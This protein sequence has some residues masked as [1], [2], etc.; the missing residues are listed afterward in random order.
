MV[1]RRRK[2]DKALPLVSDGPL[3]ALRAYRLVQPPGL[4]MRSREAGVFASLSAARRGRARNSPSQFGQ[5]PASLCSAQSAQN[6]HS[7][8]QMRASAE[9]GGRSTSQHSQ[10]GLICNM[11][12]SSILLPCLF[13]RL[14]PI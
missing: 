14:V 4:N 11:R 8:E 7:N 10:P 6:V 13:S 2:D 9:S 12:A 5:R 1:G 3:L